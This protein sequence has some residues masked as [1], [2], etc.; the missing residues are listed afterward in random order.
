MF[1]VTAMMWW[2]GRS[3][4]KDRPVPGLLVA[5]IQRVWHLLC[6]FFC[7]SLLTVCPRSQATT[8]A[9]DMQLLLSFKQQL[10]PDGRA[11]LNTWSEVD[12]NP[13]G[14]WVGIVCDVLNSTVHTVAL[15]SKSLQGTMSPSLGSLENLRLLNL[16]DNQ[17]TGEI[18]QEIANSR[19]L[20][21]LN[22]GKNMFTGSIPSSLSQLRSL[23]ALNLGDNL[24]TGAV[25][26]LQGLTNLSALR[27]NNNQLTGR[28]GN[29]TGLR[30]LTSLHL[31]SNNMAGALT[32]LEQM[33]NLEELFLHQ[34]KF[35]GRIPDLAGMQQL[36]YLDM[37][38]NELEGGVPSGIGDMPRLEY[39]NLSF[40]RLSG[41]IRRDV[42]RNS[43]DSLKTIDL[44][45]NRLNGSIPG[46]LLFWAR[47]LQ[48]LWL[49][50]NLLE[51]DIDQVW[52][53]AR[54]PRDR[55]VSELKEL[56]LRG[57]HFYGSIGTVTRDSWKNLKILD[58]SHNLLSLDIS[59][60]PR[61]LESLT[62]LQELRLG[63]NNSTGT[64]PTRSGIRLPV[65]EILDLSN[66]NLQ[67][68][69]SPQDFTNEFV[70]YLKRLDL[71]QNLLTGPVP[72]TLTG[73]AN[74]TYLD[75][76]R[77]Q[78][79]GPLPPLP[80]HLRIVNCFSPGNTGLCGPPL[81]P[82]RVPHPSRSS[83]G[84]P[85]KLWQ[86]L[87]TGG[88]LLLISVGSCVLL[89]WRW[90]VYRKKHRQD[91]DLIAALQDTGNATLMPLRELRRATSN[92][93]QDFQ[94]GVG[95]FGTVYAG[96]FTDG[97][98]VA[99]KKSK[100][101]GTA[102]DKQQFLNEVRILSQVNHRNLVRLLG[103][104]L[105]NK[106][107]LLVF[108]FVPNGTLQ[109]HLQ[110]RCD[111]G[112][113][114]LTWRQRLQIALQTADALAYLHSAANP[115]I[116]H[117]D[118]KA[119][120]IL[121][122]DN[123]H[124]KVADFGISKLASLEMTHVTMTF[125]QGTIGYIDPEYYTSY[126]YTG[127]SDVYSFGVVLLELISAQAPVDTRRGSEDASLVGWALPFIKAGNL[128]DI[129]DPEVWDDFDTATGRR[130]IARVAELAVQCVEPKSK[131]RPTMR[132]VWKELQELW[133]QPDV[134]FNCVSCNGFG[135]EGAAAQEEDDDA[136][137]DVY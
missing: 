22:L 39:L 120:N 105:E 42:W 25:P 10:N 119:A 74:L 84:I 6:K 97:T 110:G 3:N 80:P 38:G 130:S 4:M 54:P 24:L 2:R 89:G 5:H 70:P 67:G 65:L 103:C 34:N 49:S 52:T 62:S 128:A 33:H 9:T 35:T 7:I 30:K 121:L 46:E 100:R 47:K 86:L 44:S 129:I 107:A 17:L 122:D 64:L 59:A 98:T 126:Q 66:S 36:K 118:V 91:A 108:E 83:G 23:V 16:W 95:G 40:N 61:V 114:H 20:Q 51:G 21:S 29:L 28:I 43:N 81:A 137:Q 12:V 53:G 116:F 96:K 87:V 50:D 123:L 127:K 92:F 125:I 18:P 68:E 133:L 77:N 45:S 115:P 55:Q 134:H 19:N 75:L 15:P 104:C 102:E 1:E 136:E 93:S 79:R 69:I 99:I 26:S 73:I 71:S 124:A 37:S 88:A 76:S 60:S 94:I 90:K 48:R 112:G 58:L 113:S 72:A 32:N 131:D 63:S 8:L 85:V 11:A 31:N 14:R 78:L 13:C 132:D 27:L 56:R 101:E 109:E 106:I 41:E 82:C 135:T 111:R 117:R 57:N